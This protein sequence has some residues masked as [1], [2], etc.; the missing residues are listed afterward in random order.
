MKILYVSQYF[1]PEMGAPA[2]RAAELSRHW[3]A[4]GHDVTVLTG[5]PNHPT[6]IVPP[7]YRSKLRCLVVREKTD[8]VNVVRTWLLP[9]P[10]R[11]S[12]E[13]M[14]NYSSFCASA[15][16]T[17]LILSRPEVVIATS[18][19]LLVALS[20]WWLA[21]CKRV[22]F[23]FEV[24]DLWPES[25]AAVGMGNSNSLLHRILA[26][27]AGFL[28]RRSDRIVVV[29][30]AFE[31]YLVDHWRVPRE[32]I[33]V[34]ENGVETKLFAPEFIGNT[35][36]TLRR[37]LRAEG[38]FVVSYIGTMGM[39][40]GLET[41]IA[42]AAELQNTNP[43][44]VFLM[45]GEGAE[46]ERIAALARERGLNN[47]RFV[48]QQP[49]EKIPAY[50]CASDACLVLLKKTELFKTVIPTKMLE[51]MSCARPVILGVDGQARA[52]LEEAHA[53]LVIEPESPAAL[54]NAIRYLASN[55][56]VAR[57]LG[58][59]GREHVLRKFSRH[60]TAEKYIHVL[61]ALLQLPQ[62]RKMKAAA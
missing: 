30:P 41:I 47:L 54:A 37:E 29:T 58:E 48:D 9:F 31:D 18:P 51:F 57:Q 12:H 61:E 15:A 35:Q 2:A 23:V 19:Q 49:R 59:N 25:L 6:G 62:Q 5:F 44:I 43:E 8:G 13:R 50:I 38:K 60:H 53:G 14:L 42:V 32:K 10:N 7:E 40:H 36:T 52:I 24:R 27:I 3:A 22:P 56:E 26:K 39:A 17:G 55:R 16:T 21:R 34:I 46:K 4:S 20:G 28:Y 45:L 33:S 1:P 11:K